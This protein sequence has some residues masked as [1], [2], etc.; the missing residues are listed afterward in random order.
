MT[1]LLKAKIGKK[2]R[3]TL[4]TSRLHKYDPMILCI[5]TNRSLCIQ[6]HTETD[7]SVVLYEWLFHFRAILLN[8]HGN[9]FPTHNSNAVRLDM[10]SFRYL[11]KA[12]IQAYCHHDK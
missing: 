4:K 12:Q 10:R 7:L 11:K 5:T 6:K 2:A 3:K 8:L 1:N 9:V